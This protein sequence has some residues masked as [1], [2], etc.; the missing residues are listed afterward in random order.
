[1]AFTE[2][3]KIL[4]V[5][6]AFLEYLTSDIPI[7]YRHFKIPKNSG[8]WR[9]ISAPSAE[10]LLVQRKILKTL[11]ERIPVKKAAKAYKKG[12]NIKDNA[13][14]HIGQK[15]VIK[16]DL[17][18]FFNHI[19]ASEIRSIFEENFTDM[20]AD[21]LT[22]LCTLNGCLPQGAATSG[23]L[24]NLAFRQC[25]DKL[26]IFCRKNGYRYTRYADDITISGDIKDPKLIVK[27]VSKHVNSIS[28]SLNHKKTF[29]ARNGTHR[30][31]VTG[32]IVN[33]RLT[34]GRDYLRKIRQ[35]VYH[36]SKWGLD[37]HA[38]RNG[39]VNPLDC[40]PPLHGKIAYVR[41]IM[42]DKSQPEIWK[43]NLK[44]ATEAYI[45]SR[46]N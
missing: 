3:A 14:F 38:K 20:E 24:S 21:I 9:D 32:I 44:L 4:E 16:I 28:M 15:I 31:V 23:Y 36:I 33:E 46:A 26:M 8:G 2:L 45:A 35:E 29:I 41:H 39:I 25:D 11:L 13:R 30:Q 6:P 22:N 19:H 42:R 5:S 10:L 1:M 17:L 18:N 40:L 12:I 27:M 7:H 37:E 34:P 43:Q